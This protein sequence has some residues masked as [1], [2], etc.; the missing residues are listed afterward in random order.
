MFDKRQK[1]VKLNKD[2]KQIMAKN[3]MLVKG[4]S[5]EDRRSYIRKS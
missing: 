3:R 5:T 2:K 4:K 1:R